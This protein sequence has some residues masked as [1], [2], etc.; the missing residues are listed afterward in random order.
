MKQKWLYSDL[1]QDWQTQDTQ[2]NILH[3]MVR[4]AKRYS[5]CK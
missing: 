1:N 2:S 5:K 3:H 4:Q